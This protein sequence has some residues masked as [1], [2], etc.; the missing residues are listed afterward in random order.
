MLM[1]LLGLGKITWLKLVKKIVFW[2]RIPALFCRKFPEAL[3]QTLFFV[4]TR[5]W[6]AGN[7]LEVPV[8]ISLTD[9]DTHSRAAVTGGGEPCDLA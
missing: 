2:L 5:G 9:V 6:R 7:S 4:P 1:V 3:L 8:K